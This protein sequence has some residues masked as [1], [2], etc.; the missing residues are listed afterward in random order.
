VR[1]STGDEIVRTSVA[2]AAVGGS[3]VDAP[4]SRAGD[5]E[6]VELATRAARRSD[7]ASALLLKHRPLLLSLASG[8]RDRQP[9]VESAIRGS[10]MAP[11]IP[12]HTRLQIRV[13][14]QPLCRPGEVVYYLADDGYVVHRVVYRAHRGAAPDYLLTCGDNRLAPDPPVPI[15]RV[16]GIVIGVQTADGWRSPGSP[17]FR[18]R[19]TRVIRAVSLAAMIGALRLSPHAARRLALLLLKLEIAG[20]ACLR[21]VRQGLQRTPRGRAGRVAHEPGTVAIP[22]TS[23]EHRP[24]V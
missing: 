15:D 7:A 24:A 3:V 13:L 1:E 20:R 6:P 9:V 12:P 4:A 5:V 19:L 18:R 2:P 17:I 11:T 16:L 10:S 14:G 21:R 8:F 23:A 22:D